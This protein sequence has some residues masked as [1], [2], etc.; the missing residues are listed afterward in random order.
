MGQRIATALHGGPRWDWVPFLALW[1][2]LATGGALG[3]VVF[4][5]LGQLALWPACAVVVFLT[6]LVAMAERRA[7]AEP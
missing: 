4:L 1:L 6:L 7:A 5:Q 2:G 3:A